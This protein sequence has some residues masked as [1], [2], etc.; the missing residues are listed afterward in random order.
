LPFCDDCQRLVRVFKD[1]AAFINPDLFLSFRD[2]GC[3]VDFDG[4]FASTQ[5]R[6]VK[7]DLLFVRRKEVLIDFA[8]KAKD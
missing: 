7:P 1:P 5:H 4:S 3:Y 6:N 2:N 8:V